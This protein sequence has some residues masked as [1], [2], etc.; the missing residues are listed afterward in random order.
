M[1]AAANALSGDADLIAGT[2]LKVPEVASS[3]NDA[4]TFKPYNPNEIIGSTAPSLPYIPPPSSLSCKQILVLI[5]TTLIR[6]VTAPYVGVV[7]AMLIDTAMQKVE[8]N[9]GIRDHYSLGQ[10]VAA[11]IFSSAS[12]TPAIQAATGWVKAG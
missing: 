11:G 3:K 1:V 4:T 9:T 7:G 10:T 12:F 5:A 8:M 6:V 2:Q